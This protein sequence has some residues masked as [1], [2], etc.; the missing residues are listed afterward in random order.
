MLRSLPNKDD[1]TL[2]ELVTIYEKEEHKAKRAA[3]YK[4]NDNK[5]TSTNVNTKAYSKLVPTI[6]PHSFKRDTFK[7]TPP[8][9]SDT[10]PSND[11]KINAI[12]LDYSDKEEEEVY[13]RRRRP[14]RQDL[15]ANLSN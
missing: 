11:V 13:T 14:A 3:Q 5:N 15:F 6:D 7:P 2:A 9:P 10:K 8:K 12:A 4:V 1:F